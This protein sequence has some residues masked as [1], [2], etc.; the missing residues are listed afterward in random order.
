MTPRPEIR[1]NGR[2]LPRRAIAEEAQHHAAR[3]PRA[4]YEAAARAL[5]IRALLL[6]EAERRGIA[7]EPALL[8]PGKRE[9][10]EEA[11]IRALIEAA[12][13]RSTDARD[14][15]SMRLAERKWRAG[16]AR[17]VSELIGKAKI[18]GIDFAPRAG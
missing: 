1:V 3:T 13:P 15:A 14:V 2:V 18:D 16:A 8:A 7:G 17:F 12:V 9:L 6:E 4:A 10:A 11:K 5:V